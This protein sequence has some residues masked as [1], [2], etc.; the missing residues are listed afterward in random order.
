MRLRV[1]LVSL[2][3]ATVGFCA[4]V[5]DAREW[6]DATGKYKV[7][8]TLVDFR[9]GDVRLKKQSGEVISVP[10]AK[11]KKDDQNFVIRHIMLHA[12]E[13]EAE[14]AKAQPATSSTPQQEAM[15][16]VVKTEIVEKPVEV[17]G[18]RVT[19]KSG[20][21]LYVCTVNFT[22]AGMALSRDALSK[23]KI[24]DASKR[25][26]K[27][28]SNGN[29]ISK[30]DFCLRLDNATTVACYCL[31][32]ADA[33][34][35]LAIVQPRT[36]GGDN[37]LMYCGDVKFL[38]SVKPDVKPESL[39]WGGKYEAKLA[40]PTK[41]PAKTVVAQKTDPPRASPSANHAPPANAA[42]SAPDAATAA[43]AA[44]SARYARREAQLNN[45]V[46][47][48]LRAKHP[49]LA[50]LNVSRQLIGIDELWDNQDRFNQ[51]AFEALLKRIQGGR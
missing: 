38:A 18:C 34:K 8:A 4:C 13:I 12:E 5:A 24:A 39:V 7:E 48:E 45:G 26:S 3:S 37:W 20:C 46:L 2:V 21:V 33:P 19:P 44:Q 11:L 25:L 41:E 10:L 49:E 51:A 50:P 28:S 1:C 43:K 27:K 14:A 6:S 22:K 23:L 32:A 47:R 29:V 15:F 17:N 9:E 30:G 31:P 40:S 16:D 42:G 35:G 36:R